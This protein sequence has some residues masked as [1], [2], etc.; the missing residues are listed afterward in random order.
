[1]H[2]PSDLSTGI[3]LNLKNS[4]DKTISEKVYS[5]KYD[6]RVNQSL[7]LYLTLRVVM[8]LKKMQRLRHF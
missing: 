8:K 1:M 2:W 3:F 4:T 6:G 5:T 7:Q